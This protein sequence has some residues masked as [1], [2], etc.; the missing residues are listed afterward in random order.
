MAAKIEFL[1]NLLENTFGLKMLSHRA[2]RW[3]FNAAYAGLLAD[4]GYVVDCSVTPHVSWQQMKGDPT[5]QGGTDFSL[6]PEVAYHMD[7]QDIGRAG[8]SPLLEVPMTI[9]PSSAE[10]ARS[11]GRRLPQGSFVGRVWNRLFPPV[12][13]LRPNGRNL[14]GMLRVLERV[15]LE[16]RNYAEFM[17]HSSEF[18]PGGSPSFR[19]ADSIERL[20]DDLE[21]LFSAAAIHFSGATLQEFHDRHVGAS[22]NRLAPS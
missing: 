7:L 13:W 20:Y 14:R 12:L 15:R 17:L 2:G 1:T 21:Q 3:S 19:T 16:G 9:L 10:V 22:T 4:R 18:M 5:R 8:S 11:I 6:F